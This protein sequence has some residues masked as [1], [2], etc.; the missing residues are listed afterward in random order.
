MMKKN[1]SFLTAIRK[2]AFL[3]SETLL[4]LVM[5]IHRQ[6]IMWVLY[7][8]N[9]YDD[10]SHTY[11]SSKHLYSPAQNTVVFTSFMVSKTADL[12]KMLKLFVI[13]R[14]YDQS[15]TL[16]SGAITGEIYQDLH[17]KFLMTFPSLQKYLSLVA[18]QALKTINSYQYNQKMP[19]TA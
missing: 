15:L 18:W 13:H 12:E 4:K 8:K 11:D 10:I 9:F 6:E 2:Q 5:M 17:T 7:K 1:L 3:V 14:N 19:K 16:L